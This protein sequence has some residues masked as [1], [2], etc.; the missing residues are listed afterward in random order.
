MILSGNR[1]NNSKTRKTDQNHTEKNNIFKSKHW[2]EKNPPEPELFYYLKIEI[3][4]MKFLA[5]WLFYIWNWVEFT[6]DDDDDDELKLN[7]MN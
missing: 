5:F 4:S 7:K 3:K 2:P 6:M 1:G